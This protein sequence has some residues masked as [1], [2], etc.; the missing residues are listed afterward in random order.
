[1]AISRLSGDRFMTIAATHTTASYPSDGQGGSTTTAASSEIAGAPEVV[2]DKVIITTADSSASTF[3]L[4]DSGGTQF[5]PTFNVPIMA[6]GATPGLYTFDFGPSGL[7]VP[8]VSASAN[9]SLTTSVNTLRGMV[10]YR[11]VRRGG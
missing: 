3:I 7:R 5:G 4:K 10:Q 11:R 1:M 8:V 2:I 9:F 6:A